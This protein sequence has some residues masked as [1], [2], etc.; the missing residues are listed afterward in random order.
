MSR[1][2]CKVKKS[3]KNLHKNNAC[4]NL[5][6]SFLYKWEGCVR[7]AGNSRSIYGEDDCYMLHGKSDRIVDRMTFR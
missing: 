2:N 7:E 1:K 3:N 5:F 6:I 4:I